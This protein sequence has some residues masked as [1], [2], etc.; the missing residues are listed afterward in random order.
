M[1]GHTASLSEL[2]GP[3]T[4]AWFGYPDKDTSFPSPCQ[5]G[6]N[7]ESVWSQLLTNLVTLASPV[8]RR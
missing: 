7:Y 3:A 6:Q 4:C 8:D 2:Q 1:L 5:R